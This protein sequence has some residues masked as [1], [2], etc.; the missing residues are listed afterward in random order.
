MEIRR[1]FDQFIS[2]GPKQ[3]HTKVSGIDCVVV[4]PS[5]EYFSLTLSL[6]LPSTANALLDYLQP[7]VPVFAAAMTTLSTSWKDLG[8]SRT[9]RPTLKLLA[10]AILS[11]G[12]YGAELA[13]QVNADRDLQSCEAT[14]NGL[15]LFPARDPAEQKM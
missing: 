9:R 15:E 11:I 13:A 10:L 6:T 4:A 5:P 7:N 3:C 14:E 8:P 1:C 2:C 12:T